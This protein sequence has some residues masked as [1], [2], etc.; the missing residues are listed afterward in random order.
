MRPGSP[1]ADAVGAIRPATVADAAA[2]AAIYAPY[3]TDTFISFEQTPPD[4]AE[5]SRRMTSDP[6]LPW[7]VV[8][9]GASVDDPSESTTSGGADS[10][11]SSAGDRV[12]GYAYASQHRPRA[13][14]RWA[15]DCTVYLAG[16]HQRAGYG[17]RLYTALLDELRNLGYTNV[18]AGIALPNAASVGVHEAL[19][20]SR[21]GVFRRIGYKAGRW[22][23]VGWWQL[24]LQTAH[25]I[26][27]QADAVPTDPRPWQPR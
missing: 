8:T 16:D 22:Y 20:F 1:A 10:G 14:Y 13:A 4:A 11:S 9:L 26:H 2:I 7:L 27:R 6:S 19:G 17:R 25:R 21:V 12:V 23:D 15:A 5:I 18:F 3:V 24:E